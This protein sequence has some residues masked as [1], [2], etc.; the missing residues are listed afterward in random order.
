MLF[1]G[2]LAL[3]VMSTR[4]IQALEAINAGGYR[5]FDLD[6]RDADGS[7][8]EGY[9]GFATDPTRESDIQNIYDQDGQNSV[10]IARQ[11]VVEALRQHGANEL[12]IQPYTPD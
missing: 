4:M 8:V 2:G 3:K 5:T 12:D 10:F 7:T 9:V 6:V 1:T 11:R